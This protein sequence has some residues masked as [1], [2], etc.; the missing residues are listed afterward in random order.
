MKHFSFSGELSLPSFFSEIPFPEP[1]FCRDAGLGFADTALGETFLRSAAGVPPGT[2]RTFPWLLGLAAGAIAVLLCLLVLQM[3]VL[4]RQ[5]RHVAFYRQRNAD[6]LRFIRS[7]LDLCYAYRE[8]PSVFLDKFKDSVN[9]RRLQSFDLL[10]LPDEGP[11]GLKEEE[12]LLCLLIERGFTFR[13]LCVIFNLKKI[14]NVYVKY[15]RIRKKL[16]P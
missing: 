9:I 16:E 10:D 2:V 14:N 8:S 3:R 12:R 13:E 4:R 7:L 11:A 15:H 5:R 1:P 6:Q